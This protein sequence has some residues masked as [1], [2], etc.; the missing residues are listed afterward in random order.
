MRNFSLWLYRPRKKIVECKACNGCSYQ[1]I[2][3]CSDNRKRK[4]YGDLGGGTVDKIVT[5]FLCTIPEMKEKI[6][7]KF[8]NYSKAYECNWD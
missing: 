3:I 1:L 7:G 6:G 5:G 2:V 4:M 8:W